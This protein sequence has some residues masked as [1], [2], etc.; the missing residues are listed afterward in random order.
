[1]SRCLGRCA[2]AHRS[3]LFRTRRSPRGDRG[4]SLIVTIGFVVM[5]GSIAGGLAGLVTSSMNNRATLAQQRDRQYAADAAIEEAITVVRQ[6][7][8]N[9]NEA[10]ATAPGTLSTS[11]NRVTVRVDWRNACTV[12]RGA[13]G[14]VVAQR[15]VIFAA[16]VDTGRTCTEESVIVRAQVNFEQGL[17]SAVQRTTVQSWSVNR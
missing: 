4:S 16:C 6:T 11:L 5:I 9:T 13:D 15:N 8:Q 10:C 14:T 2:R 12:V 1:M 7:K 3:L 17:G